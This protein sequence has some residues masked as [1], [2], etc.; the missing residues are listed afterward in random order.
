MQAGN[1]TVTLTGT[2]SYSGGTSI[3]SGVLQVSRAANLGTGALALSGA[4]T[5]NATASF[6][7]GNAVS[8]TATNGP[9]GGIFDIDPAQTLTLSGTISGNGAL[10]KIGDGV[11]VLTG[12]N[13]YAGLTTIS[14][15]TLQLGDGGTSGSVAGDV[16][17]NASLIFNRS[18]TYTF[19]GSI[20]GSGDVTFMGGGTILFSSPYTGPISVNN[21]E[22]ILTEG[23]VTTSPFTINAGGVL[24]GTATIGRLTVNSGGTAAPGYSPGTITVNGNVT[25]NAGSVYQVDVTPSGAHDLILS[26]GLVTLSSGASVQV[27][28]VPGQYPA[29]SSYA[30]LTTSGTLTGTF[31][32]VTSDYAFLAPQLTYDAQNVYLMLTYSGIDFAE[33]AVTPNQTN[34]ANAA[35]ALGTGNAVFDAILNLPGAAVAP[36][37]NQLSGEIYASAQTVIQQQSIYLR[38]AVGARLRQS[39]TPASDTA[40]S[41][42]AKA[43]GPTTAQI[44][45]GYTP[46]MWL[47]GFGGWGE[48]SGNGNAASVSNTVG[49]VFGGIDVSVLDNLRIGLVGGYSRTSFD[50][51]ARGSS[52]TMDNYDIGLYAGYQL[53]ALALRG[54]AS[55]TWHDMSASRSIIFP[56]YAGLSDADYTL[57]TTQ[58]FGEI[59][60]DFSVGAYDFEPFVGLAYV[61]VSGGSFTETG[62]PASALSVNGEAQSTVYSTVG[63]RAATTIELSGRTFTPSLTLGWQHAFGDTD[64]SAN[65]LFA[66]GGVSPFDIQGVPI[67]EDVALL[68]VGLGYQISDTAAFQFNYTGQIA[69]QATQNTFSA[70][71]SL[72]F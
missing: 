66:N 28:A 60:Y 68:G 11:L 70:Q 25:F 19:S 72:K 49:G 2:N 65:M 20:T 13:T 37:L 24:G 55:Y 39:V 46:T 8:L 9:G 45:P 64:S 23:S 33:Y 54:G 38:E 21:S 59:G 69:E 36:A 42:A 29:N 7:F 63:L 12:T 48:T 47:E 71:F 50:V 51:D 3:Q 35:Q 32:G 41:Y 30:I 15:G 6:T 56:G 43:A 31:G 22:V 18:D 16:V 27:L 57:G 34:V 52:G 4:G 40:L 5:L 26:T 44:A 62:S 14:A 67:A 53:G 61:H 58:L 17:N 1:G 10:T